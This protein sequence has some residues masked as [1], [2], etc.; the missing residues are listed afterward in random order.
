MIC[1]ENIFVAIKFNLREQN[2]MW[3]GLV[4]NSN[5]NLFVPLSGYFRRQDFT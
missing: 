2:A 5:T 3:K 4:V 1:Q